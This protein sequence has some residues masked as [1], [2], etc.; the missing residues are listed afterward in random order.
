MPLSASSQSLAV[1]ALALLT[2]ACSG[3]GAIV[4]SGVTVLDGS[5]EPPIRNANVVV[6]GGVISRLGPASQVSIPGG[7]QVTSG[8]D[9]YLF[10]LDASQRIAIGKRADFL[11][12]NANPALEI[13]YTQHVIG[14]MEQGR[15]IQQPQ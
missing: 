4:I 5:V 3:S 2:S 15:W 6:S 9:R 7:A 14:R 13:N 8:K 11:L 12:L 1:M 10:P